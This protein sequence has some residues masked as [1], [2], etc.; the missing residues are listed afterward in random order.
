MRSSTRLQLRTVLVSDFFAPLPD[1]TI[2]DS[3]IQE[4]IKDIYPKLLTLGREDPEAIRWAIMQQEY[5]VSVTHGLDYDAR[6]T[7]VKVLNE[8]DAS[9]KLLLR[10][11][12]DNHAHFGD[13]VAAMGYLAAR[14]EQALVKP[15]LPLLT[16]PLTGEIRSAALDALARCGVQEA[17]PIV[18]ELYSYRAI[19]KERTPWSEAPDI[20]LLRALWQGIVN[21]VREG[22]VMPEEWLNPWAELLKARGR[23]GDSTALRD[24]IILQSD[25]D[26]WLDA[27]EGFDALIHHLGGLRNALSLLCENSSFATLEGQLLSLADHD[28][29]EAVRQWANDQLAAMDPEKYAERS[30][31]YLDQQA[32]EWIRQTFQEWLSSIQDPYCEISHCFFHP[33]QSVMALSTDHGVGLFRRENLTPFFSWSPEEDENVQYLDFHP[34]KPLIIA[35]TYIQYDWGIEGQIYLIDYE[36][37]DAH[38]LLEKSREVRACWF[39]H[40]GRIRV[41]FGGYSEE[42]ESCYKV[43]LPPGKE[44]WH[45]QELEPLLTTTV[46]DCLVDQHQKSGS[47]QDFKEYQQAY[48]A[49]HDQRLVAAL[50][51]WLNNDQDTLNKSL[52]ILFAYT[53]AWRS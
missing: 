7:L 39:L 40:E 12:L 18:Q 47:T 10:V 48:Y 17:L 4:R 44:P 33:D 3:V 22:V 11:A 32:H 38:L 24:L 1:E 35:A 20:S 26:D 21:W 23:L 5:G 16:K 42:D 49:G 41:I 25:P 37:N 2:D 30:P 31:R 19:A 29:D 34:L 28:R 52:K 43:D 46:T 53:Q 51:A 27:V 13:R 15:L 50:K 14:N 6:Q 8:V 36:R 9:G 45:A